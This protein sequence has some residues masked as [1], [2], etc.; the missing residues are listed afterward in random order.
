MRVYRAV[1]PEYL[2]NIQVNFHFQ[3]VKRQSLCP[4]FTTGMFN[5]VFIAFNVAC[6]KKRNQSHYR[7]EVPRGFQKVN[8]PRLRDN[9][10][11]WW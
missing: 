8:V 5:D 7:P 6:K 4:A 11:E 3:W 2:N 9:G 1:G 10:P